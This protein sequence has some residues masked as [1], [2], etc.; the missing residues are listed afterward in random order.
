MSQPR[1][2]IFQLFMRSSRVQKKRAVLTIAAIAWG[3]L[4][5]LLLLA[6]GEGLGISLQD[7]W[8]GM[9]TDIAVIWPG[10]TTKPW[11]GLPAG[12]P[13]RPRIDDIQTLRLRVPG[14]IGISGE[15]T[16]WR[17]TLTYGEKTVT[18]R[19]KGVSTVWGQLRNQIP[20]SGGRFLN[21][22]DDAQRRRVIFLGTAVAEDIFGS[23]DPVGKTLLVDQVPY[24]V[25]G[26]MIEKMQFGAYSGM[27]ADHAIIP[28]RTFYAQYGRDRLGNIVLK[29]ED[30]RQMKAKLAEVAA[31]LSSK[32]GFDPHDERV[33]GTWDTV[34]SGTIQNNILLGI[35]IFL[36]VIGVLTLTVGG[37]GVANI[38][39]AVVKERTREIGVKMALG[40]RSHWITGPIVLEGLTY[41]LLGGVLGLVMATGLILLMSLLPTG[42][43]MALKAL[44]KPTL[45]PAI[46]ATAA[47]VLGIIGLLAGYFPARRA[48]SVDPA[49]TLRYE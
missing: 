31:V 23:E 15:I 9:G 33:L 29:S 22:L 21:P 24:T 4:A 18:G 20:V 10:E 14:L 41:T 48:A 47:G 27:D 25:I 40:A 12:R 17:T 35:K 39:Y 2:M 19:V 42:D 38:M 30:P 16:S 13:I 11:K 1:F 49:E 34:E 37:I 36:S 32:Y 8:A 5:L 26:V 6:F 46:A 45:S 43:D 7:A 28:I 3:T 44:G